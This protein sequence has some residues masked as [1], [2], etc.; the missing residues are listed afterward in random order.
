M[1]SALAALCKCTYL[2][3]A[4]LT[5]DIM[6]VLSK[7]AKQGIV[8]LKKGASL[9]VSH[10]N[11]DCATLLQTLCHDWQHWEATRIRKADPS[12]LH[13]AALLQTIAAFISCD[14]ECSR[15]L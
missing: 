5:C 2:C 8:S 7:Y 12:K 13:T 14:L 1:V 11:A 10:Y 6:P 3:D 4:A 15:K 9:S